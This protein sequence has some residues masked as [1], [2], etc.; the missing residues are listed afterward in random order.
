MF[1]GPGQ[2]IYTNKI[3]SM[4]EMFSCQNQVYVKYIYI[5]NTTNLIML[6]S[7]DPI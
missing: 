7:Y 6:V 5:L 1:G 4:D 2:Y 3:I